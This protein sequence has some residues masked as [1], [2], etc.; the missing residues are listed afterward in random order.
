MQETRPMTQPAPRGGGARAAVL[1]TLLTACGSS[2]DAGPQ[3]I[4]ILSLSNRAD[5]ISD[6]NAYLEILLPKGIPAGALKVELNGA[7]VTAQF[8]QRANGRSEEHTSELQSPCNL[9]C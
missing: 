2:G 4:E 1:A 9:V 7:D 5:M 3:P 6:G 8:A